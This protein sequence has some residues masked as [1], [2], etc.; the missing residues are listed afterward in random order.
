M[1]CTILR[2]CSRIFCVILGLRSSCAILRNSRIVQQIFCAILGLRS[3]IFCAILG[4]HS[5]MF[6]AILGLY[7]RIFC[8]ILGLHSRI[9]CAILGLRSRILP[10][11]LPPS[12]ERRVEQLKRQK[13]RMTSAKRR[14]LRLTIQ[15]ATSITQLQREVRPVYLMA[16]P[17]S[18]IILATCMWWQPLLNS[19]LI[20]TLYRHVDCIN[21]PI[22]CSNYL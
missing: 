19:W 14:G 7:S 9:L 20:L 1:F 10:P 16:A 12:L 2:L 3:R 22:I 17:R 5:R 18:K 11:S 21:V 8:T 6:C 4:L 15:E 13:P